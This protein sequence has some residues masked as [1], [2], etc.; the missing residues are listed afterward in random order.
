MAAGKRR[1]ARQ[2]G[3]DNV[4]AFS[5]AASCRCPACGPLASWQPLRRPSCRPPRTCRR[6]SGGSAAGA[7]PQTRSLIADGLGLPQRGRLWRFWFIL[8][9]NHPSS[10]GT[11][12]SQR[13]AH[14]R[15]VRWG[16]TQA[17]RRMGQSHH[18]KLPEQTG[19]LHLEPDRRS[20]RQVPAVLPLPMR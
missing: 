10:C 19:S 18:N 13:R 12:R 16:R 3:E 1:R 17:G 5:Q 9:L 2:L 20:T 6:Q 4:G 14:R 7:G 15:G 11:I 8:A